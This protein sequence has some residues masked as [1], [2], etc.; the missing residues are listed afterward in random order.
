MKKFMFL[1]MLL[2]ISIQINA[3]SMTELEIQ[4]ENK[5]AKAC[6]L[7][8]AGYMFG[9]GVELDYPKGLIFLDKACS[10]GLKSSCDIMKLARKNQN[11]RKTLKNKKYSQKVCTQMT[12]DMKSG[13][14]QGTKP[15]YGKMAYCLGLACNK[16]NAESC[17]YAGVLYAT[18]KDPD[19]DLFLSHNFLTKSC[20]L[21]SAQDCMLVGYNYEAGL[22]TKQDYSKAKEF[23]GKACDGGNQIGCN[24]F[25]KLNKGGR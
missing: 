7:V 5:D 13:K 24:S 11:K 23:Y 25:T 12:D 6:N 9:A 2:G 1:M 22:G 21:G 10:L 16:G 18:E 19:Q 4:C 3:N 15:D 8:A 20:V 14:L 17:S